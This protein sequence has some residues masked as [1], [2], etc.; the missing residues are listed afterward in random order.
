MLLLKS[1]PDFIHG[2]KRNQAL[3][4]RYYS[5]HSFNDPIRGWFS[6]ITE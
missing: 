1:V 5:E 6:N 4:C 3:T 2:E